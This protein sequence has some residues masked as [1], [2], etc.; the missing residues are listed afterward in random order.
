M[1]RLR[2]ALVLG[3]NGQDGSYLVD[4]LLAVGWDVVGVGRQQASR[5][6]MV[7]PTH[8]RYI[9]SD[10]ADQRGIFELL[11]DVSP[12]YVFH[13]AATHG[14]AGFVYEDV[15]DKV[16]QVNTQSVLAIL[17]YLRRN[18]GCGLSYISSSKVFGVID[19]ARIHEMS[20][21]HST[22]LYSISKNT[23]HDLINY[24][25]AKHGVQASV[26]WT[27]NH[28]SPRRGAEYFIPRLAQALVNA[29]SNSAHQ[30][31]FERLSFWGNWG[32]ASEYMQILVN[33]AG[34]GVFDDF[35][36]AS[37]QT[38]WAEHLVQKLFAAR[39]LDWTDH[40]RVR[41]PGDG[42]IPTP[43]AVDLSKIAQLHGNPPMQTARDVT[44]EIV[45]ALQQKQQGSH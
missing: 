6:G 40:I 25:R 30:E 13:A 45:R 43:F 10:V 29:E 32:A 37:P 38:V 11:S 16:L 28:E 36:L 2:R 31:T 1:S 7:S 26:V 19:S 22:C 42:T 12:D 15:W 24:Y 33:L 17:E 20:A 23:S 18:K 9:Q 41:I 34:R 5:Q 35:I 44:E 3:A 39:G 27:F 4:H 21:R 8:Y 14:M